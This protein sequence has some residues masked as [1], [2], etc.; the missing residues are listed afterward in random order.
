VVAV[1]DNGVG[2]L[3]PDLNATL[4]WENPDEVWDD[5]IDNDANG[6]V[7]DTYG[8]DF[9]DGDSFPM[10]Q[11]TH[12]S[13]VAG[14]VGA[15]RDNGWGTC[16]TARD[17]KVLPSRLLNTFGSVTV[18]DTAPIMGYLV[19]LRNQGHPIFIANASYDGPV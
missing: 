2:W 19:N 7:E 5:G 12:G 9:V 13:H 10:D 16:G 4:M 11:N 3:H 1:I 6:Y 14:I 18:A 8:W 17:V 15:V